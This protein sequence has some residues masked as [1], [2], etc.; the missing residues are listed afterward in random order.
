MKNNVAEDI[1][2]DLDGGVGV[3][4]DEDPG[5][6]D[7]FEFDFSDDGSIKDGTYHATVSEFASKNS[8]AGN[9]MYVYKFN[10]FDTDRELDFYSP[11]VPTARW[12]AAETLRAVGISGETMTRFKASDVIGKPCRVVIVNEEFTPEDG[13]P[14]QK[15]PKI[16]RVLPPDAETHAKVAAFAM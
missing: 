8:K 3:F 7:S 13:T 11:L 12:K 14:P 4:A 6:L 16:V 10:L 9:K 5:E 1:L 2:K 15:R